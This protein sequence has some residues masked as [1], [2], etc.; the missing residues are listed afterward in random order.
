MFQR[1]GGLAVATA[2]LGILIG[3]TQMLQNMAD[4]SAIGPALSLSMLTVFYGVLLS[5]AVFRS[6]ATDS[7][8]GYKLKNGSTD[9]RTELWASWCL[10]FSWCSH[11]HS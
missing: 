7:G 1:L 3:M 4:P 6:A 9:T 10:C 2:F 8:V 11:G 5:E